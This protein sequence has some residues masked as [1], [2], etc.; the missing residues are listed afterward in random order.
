MLLPFLMFV[1]LIVII[2]FIYRAKKKD[3]GS[4]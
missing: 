3:K 4:I 2:F 1:G